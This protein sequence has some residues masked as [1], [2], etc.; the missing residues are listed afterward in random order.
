MIGLILASIWTWSIIIDKVIA[1]KRMHLALNRFEQVFWS[2]QSLEELYRSLSDRKTAGIEFPGWDATRSNLIAEVETT[3][4]TP[5]DVPDPT[6][7][8]KPKPSRQAGS[9][10]SEETK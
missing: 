2:G 8:T 4:E 9:G 1:Y 6:P 5:G 7:V 10:S 3:E